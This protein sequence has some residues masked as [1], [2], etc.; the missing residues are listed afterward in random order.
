ML[1]SLPLPTNHG[2]F[3]LENLKQIKEVL[4]RK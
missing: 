2:E 1:F 4:K 3:K